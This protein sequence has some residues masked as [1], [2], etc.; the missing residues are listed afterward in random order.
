M[1]KNSEKTIGREETPVELG[2]LGSD[3]A[4]LEVLHHVEVAAII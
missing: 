2:T 3:T 4:P 1:M